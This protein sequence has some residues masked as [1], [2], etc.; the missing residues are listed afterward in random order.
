MSAARAALKS[1]S[2]PKPDFS[3]P[4]LDP[5]TPKTPADEGLEFFQSTVLGDKPIQVYELR[6]DADGGPNKDAS[7]SVR[8]ASNDRAIL[9]TSAVHPSAAR[10]CAIHSSR[11]DRCRDARVEEWGFQDKLPARRR[12]VWA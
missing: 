5:T 9:N 2:I 12:E 1:V 8:L 10:V 3:A 7:V 11:I 4:S 6:L